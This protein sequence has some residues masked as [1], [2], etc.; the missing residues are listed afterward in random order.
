[1]NS[2]RQDDAPRTLREVGYILSTIKEDIDELKAGQIG[3]QNN[4]KRVVQTLVVSVLCPL[5]VGGIL[6]YIFNRGM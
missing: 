1:M 5:I 2:T 3:L 6:A 4:Q